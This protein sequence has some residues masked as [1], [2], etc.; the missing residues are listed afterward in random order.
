MTPSSDLL[1]GTD[2]IPQRLMFESG[3]TLT[4]LAVATM[5]ALG[6]RADQDRA[7]ADTRQ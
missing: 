3:P 1:F 4:P 2:G 6:G 7:A 5:S